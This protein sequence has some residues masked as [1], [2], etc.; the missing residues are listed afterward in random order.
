MSDD[1]LRFVDE[2]KQTQDTY[3]YLKPIGIRKLRK[4]INTKEFKKNYFVIDT[5]KEQPL[6]VHY[7]PNHVKT[8]QSAGGNSTSGSSSS[9]SSAPFMN[10]NNQSHHDNQTFPSSSHPPNKSLSYQQ[11]GKRVQFSQRNS[12]SQPYPA[13]HQ[14]FMMMNGA[15]SDSLVGNNGQSGSLSQLMGQPCASREMN[16]LNSR[17]TLSMPEFL[18]H[19]S[20]P[21]EL[22]NCDE[23]SGQLFDDHPQNESHPLDQDYLMQTGGNNENSISPIYRKSSIDCQF[24]PIDQQMMDGYAPFLT[25]HSMS[26]EDEQQIIQQN[27]QT[28]IHSHQQSIQHHQ[29]L[30]KHFSMNDIGKLTILNGLVESGLCYNNDTVN[31]LE[32]LQMACNAHHQQSLMLNMQCQQ[33][34]IPHQEAMDE[35]HDDSMQQEEEESD[36]DSSSVANTAIRNNNSFN[37]GNIS[38]EQLHHDEMSSQ[39]KCNVSENNQPQEASLE[40]YS[41]LLINDN[42]LFENNIFS[43]EYLYEE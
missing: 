4:Q 3:S 31:I 32:T 27:N 14:Q 28:E 30:N 15:E 22:E 33:D 18:A 39:E 40:E 10:S 11:S 35:Q 38:S 16:H 21:T 42:E 17:R 6:V 43:D 5:R 34:Q 36:C 12:I 8:P 19:Y 20:P 7:D 13:T 25:P 24:T 29:L 23:T 41:D 1:T 37:D 9:T 26:P 2:T